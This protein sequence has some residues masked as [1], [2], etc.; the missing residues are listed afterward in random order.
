MVT[1]ADIT[2]ATRPQ[3]LRD[4]GYASLQG[5]AKSKAAKA[6][7]RAGVRRWLRMS[8]NRVR[9]STSLVRRYMRPSA[10]S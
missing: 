2:D 10:R 6:L 7:V 5:S 4:A 9:T 8:A 3:A 1:V